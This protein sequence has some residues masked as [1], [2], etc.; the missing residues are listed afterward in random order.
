[1]RLIHKFQDPVL[2]DLFSI[3]LKKQNID[4]QLE[5]KPN[6][7][8]GSEDYGTFDCLLWI[9]DENEVK[10]ALHFLDEYLQNPHDSRFSM[11]I[12]QNKPPPTT[13]QSLLKIFKPASISSN[14]PKK[15][16]VATLSLLLAC[17]FLF[18]YATF[19]TP[20]YAPYSE[21]PGIPSFSAPV[22]K[23]LYFDYPEAWSIIDKLIAL[24]GMEKVIHSNAPLPEQGQLLV[25]KFADTP[26]WNGLYPMAMSYLTKGTPLTLS[27]APMFEKIR[28][29]EYWRAATPILL[30]YNFLHLLFN[31]LWLLVLGELVE[32]R[33]GSP[34]FLLI[35]LLTAA[36]SNLAQ[37][38]MTG[39]NFVGIS[40]VL[41]GLFGF[42]W[43]RQRIAPNEQYNLLPGILPGILLFV[44]AMAALQIAASM[45]QLVWGYSFPIGIANT[46]HIA[47][48]ITGYLL[49]CLNLFSTRK[50]Y[51]HS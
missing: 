14:P 13:L 10:P 43:A 41:C 11:P 26:Y 21:I 42:I 39:S 18:I 6:R 48:G 5:I 45:I 29:G 33:I 15:V 30:H 37:Y 22:E 44:F 38:L 2:A 50:S 24:Y 1:M 17:V 49:G 7:D 36:T 28:Q 19:T 34:R 9:T 35:V 51:N 20:S 25:K 27:E 46:A 3:F 16:G 32:E 8:W 31:M 23:T 40:G 47:G 12:Q 4:N